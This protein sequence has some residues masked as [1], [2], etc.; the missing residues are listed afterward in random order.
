MFLLLESGDEL[1][2][3]SGFALLL[4]E[5]EAGPLPNVIRVKDRSR[6]RYAITEHPAQLYAIKSRPRNLYDVSES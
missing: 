5:V 6:Q 4:E 2:L 3:E 1:L